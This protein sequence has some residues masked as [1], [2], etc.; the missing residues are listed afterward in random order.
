MGACKY[1]LSK[2]VNDKDACAFKAVVQNEHR[3]GNTRMSYT[4]FVE[5]AVYGMNITLNK[6]D[7]VKVKRHISL[8][9]YIFEHWNMGINIYMSYKYD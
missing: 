7:I 5:V 4:Q 6:K 8:D 2:S 9:F 1:L 3:Y